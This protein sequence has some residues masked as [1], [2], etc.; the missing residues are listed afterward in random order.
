MNFLDDILY[1][2]LRAVRLHSV[3]DQ[4]TNLKHAEH[5]R[6]VGEG[7]EDLKPVLKHLIFGSFLWVLELWMIEG[8]GFGKSVIKAVD[9]SFQ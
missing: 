9:F 1:H 6:W 8:V 2:R 3:C 7:H 5:Y 4:S